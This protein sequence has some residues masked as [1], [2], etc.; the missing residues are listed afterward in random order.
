[1]RAWRRLKILN[2]GAESQSI[3]DIHLDGHHPAVPGYLVIQL[4]ESDRVLALILVTTNTTLS[5]RA[6][7][8]GQ[9]T[10]P[11]PRPTVCCRM[12]WSRPS[13]AAAGTARSSCR[14]PP[15]PHQW[16]RSRR[17][18]S[19][20]WTPGCS[21]SPWRGRSPALSCDSLRPRSRTYGRYLCTPH[22]CRRPQQHRL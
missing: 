7:R 10:P 6:S 13:S 11:P 19:L 12:R 22:W 9:L 2:L 8:H 5:C 4:P 16:R 20:P 14:I 3:P 18:P 21:E 15:C 17:S 1:M